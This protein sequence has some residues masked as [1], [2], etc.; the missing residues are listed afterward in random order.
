M[1]S[2]VDFLGSAV[3]QKIL[4]VLS[5]CLQSSDLILNRTVIG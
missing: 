2:I 5:D 4:E 3:C 1:A